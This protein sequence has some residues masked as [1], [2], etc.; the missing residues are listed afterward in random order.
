MGLRCT[1]WWRR[2][3]GSPLQLVCGEAS[4]TC[5]RCCCSSTTSFRGGQSLSPASESIHIIAAPG[6]CSFW[7]PWSISPAASGDSFWSRIPSPYTAISLLHFYLMSEQRHGRASWT[8]STQE[9][10]AAGSKC[11]EVQRIGLGGWSMRVSS[12]CSKVVC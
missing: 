1:W 8:P 9:G 5:A 6:A 3:L 12:W 10:A 11:T 4:C 2:G 7:E